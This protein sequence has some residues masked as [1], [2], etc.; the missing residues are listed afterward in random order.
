VT[1][2]RAVEKEVAGY[3]SGIS[4]GSTEIFNT[5]MKE[6]GTENK[7]VRV[8]FL[9]KLTFIKAKGAVAF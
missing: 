1:A 6:L 8:L 4:Y 2:E 9:W 3:S 7:D 5:S